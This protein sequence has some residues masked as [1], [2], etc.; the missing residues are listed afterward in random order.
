M[1]KPTHHRMSVPINDFFKA[2]HSSNF[3]TISTNGKTIKH[4]FFED[5][6]ERMDNSTMIPFYIDNDPDLLERLQKAF[7]HLKTFYKKSNYREAF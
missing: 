6:K 3:F 4:Y 7:I 2:E 5:N 1:P